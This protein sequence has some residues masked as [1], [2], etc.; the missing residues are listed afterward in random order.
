MIN[1]DSEDPI[2]RLARQHAARVVAL[3][4]ARRWLAQHPQRN[5]PAPG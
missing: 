3:A 5:K 4:Q 2:R 1:R